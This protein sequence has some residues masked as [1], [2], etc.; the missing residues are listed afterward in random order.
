MKKLRSFLGFTGVLMFL[1]SLLL[2][3]AA[4]KGLRLVSTTVDGTPMIFILPENGQAFNRPFVMVA[5]GFAGSA[6]LM[7]GFGFTLAHAGYTVAL[8]DFNGHAANPQ[9]FGTLQETNDLQDNA[10]AVLYEAERRDLVQAGRWAV[11]GHSMGSGVAMTFGQDFPETKATIAVSPVSTQVTPALPHNLLLMAG[12]LE[13]NFV[14]NARA[15]LAEAGG[16]GGSL[17]DGSA[18]ALIIIPN[19]EHISILFSPTAHAAAREW[20][21]ATFGVQPGAQDYTDRRILWLALGVLG[22]VIAGAAWIPAVPAPVNVSTRSAWHRLLALVG[23]ALCGTL[24]LWLLEKVGFTFDSLFGLLVGGYL[25]LWFCFSGLFALWFMGTLSRSTVKA[26]ISGLLVFG[27][28][29]VGLGLLSQWVW[30]PWLLISKRLLL[31]LPSVLLVFPWFLAVGQ[32]SSPAKAAGWWGWWL[33]N[34]LVVCGSLMIAMRLNSAIGFIMLLL[35]MFPLIFVLQ[36]LA[37]VRQRSPWAYGLGSALLTGWAILVV[38][39]LV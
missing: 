2:T 10:E 39:P 12:S 5:H 13:P 9:P 6:Q 34:T 36:S 4:Q 35:P 26:W 18:R 16:S 15:R 7:K 19:V 3:G 20:L 32:A 38:F 33:V 22:A 29:W 21:D 24:T 31:W 8:W 25:V 23:G 28:L 37:A 11:V 30:L 14:E 27:V 17:Q 1:A